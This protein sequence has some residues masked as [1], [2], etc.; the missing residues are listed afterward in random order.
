MPVFVFLGKLRQTQ[1]ISGRFGFIRMLEKSRVTPIDSGTYLVEFPLEKD[2]LMRFY[3]RTNS[4]KGPLGLL[5]LKNIHLPNK[6]FEV[7]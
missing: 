4:G 6:I 7:K 5:E 2:K 3:M 1:E